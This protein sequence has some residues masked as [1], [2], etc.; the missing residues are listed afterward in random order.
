MQ[1]P[2]PSIREFLTP[3]EDAIRRYII[4]SERPAVLRGVV[5]AWP[6][7]AVSRR[8]P[9]AAV[10]YLRRFD[11]GSPVDAIMTP[12]EVEGRVFYDDHMNGFNFVRNR[13]SITAIAEQ[14]LRYAA[15]ARP[16]A[17]AAQ[18]ALVRDCLPGFCAENRLAVMDDTVLPRIWL[19]NA[20]TTPTHLDEWN[21]IGCVVSGRRR[22]TLFP[23]EQIANLYIGPLD[24]APTGAPMSL[25]PLREP[26]FTRF[27][28][29]RE[30]LAAAVSAELGPGDAIFIPPLWWHHVESLEP[31]NVLI[32]YWWRGAVGAATA[33]DSAFD[34]LIHAMLNLRPLPPATRE[35]WRAIFDH[36]V[37]GAQAGVTEHIPEHRHGIL[38]KVSAADAVRLRAYL[39]ERLQT[40]K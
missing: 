37:F 26:D 22:F 24:F 11:N 16:P 38:G 28:K 3:D 21:N 10:E 25:V 23:P 33:T 13:L 39:A 36:Y 2:I 40:W 12:P 7:V 15:F 1:Q 32:N 34:S 18:S 20:I 27:P 4:E 30:A 14:V 19:G 9:A 35:A 5:G 29:F 8:S 17:V 31:F 6:M